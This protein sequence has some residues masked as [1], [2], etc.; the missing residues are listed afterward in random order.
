MKRICVFC[1]S[2]PGL[3]PEY[4]AAAQALGRVMAGRGIGL[5]YGGGHVGLMGVVADAIMAHGGE[6]IGVIPEALLRR[7]V[8]HHGLTELHVVRSMH[9]RKQL[10]ADL[11]DGFIAMP[12]GYGTFEEFCEVITWSQLGIHPKPCAL[13]NVLGYYDALLAM[14][15]H[16]VNEGF[17]RPHH[18]AMVLEDT[19]PATLVERMHAF[20]P[21]DA[22]KWIEPAE[23]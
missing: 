23:R 7:E 19:D 17:I 18:R 12:G 4:A 15:D 21:P 11:S 9:E 5:V 16:G 22:E 3:R 10:M 20:V 2:S 6:A 1:G 14:F 8:G 13:L